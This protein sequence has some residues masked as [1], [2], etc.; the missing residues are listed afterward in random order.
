M[1]IQM[2]LNKGRTPVLVWT[3]DI[4]HEAIQQLVNVS[5]L[6]IIHGHIAAMPDVHAGIG[7]TVG[8]VIPT[9]SA[10]IPAAVGVDIGCGM[11]AVRLSIKASD[12]PDNLYRI[13]TAIETAVPVGFSQHD[14]GKVRGSQHARTARVLDQR[15]DSIV[16]KHPALMKMQKR[17]NETWICQIGTLGGG[18]HF[19]ELC[20]DEEQFVWVMLHSGSR[21]I[22]NVMGRYFINA[23][24]KDMQRH[25][26]NLPDADLAYFSEGSK[27]FDDYVEAVDWAQDYALLNRREMMRLVLGVLERELSPRINAWKVMGEAINCHHNYVQRETHFGESVFVTRKGA[28]SARA[29]ELGIIPGSMGAKSYIVRGLGN[30]QSLC[31]CSHGAGRRMS[32]TAAKRKFSRIDLEA[33]TKGVECRKDGGVLD[34][35][36]GAYKDIDAVMANQTDLV[37]VMHT[38]KQVICVK[39]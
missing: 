25:K 16:G 23:A 37:E 34:E 27:W 22:G 39:G 5:Q 38:L 1:G 13:R 26:M 2:T 30:P 36:P 33:Q 11:N 31:S 3:R 9:K 18:N 14:A 12:L 15:L 28:I 7:A 32:R 35:I 21:G 4:E 10:I 24:K 20:L 6:P 19:I 17:F 29:G 8:S